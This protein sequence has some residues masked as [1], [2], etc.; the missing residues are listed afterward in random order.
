MTFPL[1]TIKI[2]NDTEI[3]DITKF[4]KKGFDMATVARCLGI[5]FNRFWLD[6]NNPALNV[7]EAYDKGIRLGEIK[8]RKNMIK[9]ADKSEGAQK[10]FNEEMQ[11]S[12]L[13]NKIDSIRAS[14]ENYDL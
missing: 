2:Y 1:R 4:A 3:T 6:Y 11:A 7:R 13:R 8:N 9:A 12:K 5:P 14:R 10:N